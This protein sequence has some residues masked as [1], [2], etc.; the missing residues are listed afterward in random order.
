LLQAGDPA[1]WLAAIN[2][3]RTNTAL[4]PTAQTGFTGGQTSPPFTDTFCQQHVANED[5]LPRARVLDVQ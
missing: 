5:E 4:Y 2:T 1:G 3:L